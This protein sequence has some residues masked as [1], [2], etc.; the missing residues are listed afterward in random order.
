VYLLQYV[1][2]QIHKKQLSDTKVELTL[3]ADEKML[4]EAKQQVLQ[5]LNRTQVKMAGFRPGK[6]PLNLVEKNTD[7][8][9]L[10]S[11]VLDKVVNTLY[12]SAIEQERVRPVDRPEISIKKFVPFTTLEVTAVVEAVGEVKLPDYKKVK[13]T[14]KS[15]EVTDKDVDEVI[16]ALR[17]RGA[18]KKDIE[19]AA[20]KDD[21]VTIDFAGRD[22]NT[23][24]AINGA[25]GKD[26]PIVVGSNSFI[27]GFEDNLI[28]MKA[29][30]EKE[31]TLTFPKDYGVSALQSRKVT[32]KVTA[33][34][35]QELQ[36]PEVNDEFAAKV[37]PVKT[38]AELKKDIK[39]QVGAE[40]QNQL[41]REFE[42]ELIEKLAEKSTV[43]IPK[44]LVDEEIDR[45]EAEEKQNLVYRGQTWQ[46]HLKEEGVDE[47]EHREQKRAAAENRVKAGL[48]LSEIAVQEKINV[49]PEEL[50]VRLQLLKGQYQDKQ[51]QAE[52][53]KPEN[54]REI[55]GRMVTEKT[56]NTLVTYATAKA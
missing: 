49:T 20:T 52:L 5:T 12:V 14:R 3:V 4:S 45:I 44:V 51:M 32:F 29:G 2:M 56:I 9:T 13:M 10:Q 47:K 46:E 33:I 39:T 30:E 26:Y 22:A 50:E 40:R 54:R 6:A 23:N 27:P 38:V 48:V 17:T 16:E 41:D 21:E 43:A 28:G 18:E 7:P 55:A 25:D 15:V 36:K 11:E 19:R 34:N 42:S 8:A 53:D 24:E 1:A 35:I 37:A 31:F